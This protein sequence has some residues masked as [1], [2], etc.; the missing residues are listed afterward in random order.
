MRCSFQRR[1]RD[2]LLLIVIRRRRIMVRAAW[3]LLKASTR[4]KSCTVTAG[5]TEGSSTVLASGF[6]RNMCPQK[7][8]MRLLMKRTNFDWRH[9]RHLDLCSSPLP[10]RWVCD[11]SQ[12]MTRATLSSRPKWPRFGLRAMFVDLE[13]DAPNINRLPRY[14]S[15]SA[16][17]AAVQP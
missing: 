10:I 2:E 1:L 11:S 9:T 17:P 7:H 5:H 15:H 16:T 3:P 6:R 13:E 8:R 4:P 12:R 14:M